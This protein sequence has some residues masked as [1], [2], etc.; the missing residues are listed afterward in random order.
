[1]HA[2]TWAF[3]AIVLGALSG[4]AAT[5]SRPAGFDVLIARDAAGQ[6]LMVMPSTGIML[7]D[8]SRESE[9]VQVQLT[10]AGDTESGRMK[11]YSANGTRLIADVSIRDIVVQHR[12]NLRTA[13]FSDGETVPAQ[14]DQLAAIVDGK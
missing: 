11:V 5:S 7:R 4:C 12:N 13:A 8:G 1:M 3:G 14:P 10:S 6:R 2:K 9:D